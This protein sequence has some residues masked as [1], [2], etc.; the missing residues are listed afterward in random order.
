MGVLPGQ[1]VAARRPP[2]PRRPGEGEIKTVLGVYA[3]RIFLKHLDCAVGLFTSKQTVHLHCLD[4]RH[5]E[6][7]FMNV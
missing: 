2:G 7:T 6:Q 4:G 3:E 5:C 1:I